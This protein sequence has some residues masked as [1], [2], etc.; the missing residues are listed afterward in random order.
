VS[1]FDE[2]NTA[3]IVKKKQ[4][5]NYR[6]FLLNLI[7]FVAIPITIIYFSIRQVEINKQKYVN[8]QQITCPSLLSIARSARDTLIVMRD[9]SMCTEYMLTHLK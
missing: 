5:L 8:E 4:A 6:R 1:K 2:L 9:K 7:F 3:E